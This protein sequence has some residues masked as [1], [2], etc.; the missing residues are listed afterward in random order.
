VSAGHVL[1]GRYALGDV[2][3]RGAMGVVFRARDERLG[4][5]VAVKLLQAAAPSLRWRTT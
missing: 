5:D 3:G 2:I 4:R 1:D